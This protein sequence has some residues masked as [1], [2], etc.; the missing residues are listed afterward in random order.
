[1][2]VTFCHV[3]RVDSDV[4][5]TLPL[6]Q[7]DAE[8]EERSGTPVSISEAAVAAMRSFRSTG[9]ATVNLYAGN[10]GLFAVA[11]EGRARRVPGKDLTLWRI[12][13]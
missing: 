1:M 9:G 12:E 6:T 3:P 7:D 13:R 10:L 2:L 4:R 5:R 11:V 8:A